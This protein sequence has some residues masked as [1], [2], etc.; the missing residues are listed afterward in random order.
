[1]DSPFWAFSLLN[2]LIVFGSLFYLLHI[3]L[4][5]KLLAFTL[6]LNTCIAASAIYC[7]PDHWV[8]LILSVLLSGIFFYYI[9]K[10]SIAFL[11]SI[12]IL[13]LAVLVEYASLLLIESLHLSI[14]LHALLVAL[15]FTSALYAY[16]KF[17]NKMT[18]LPLKIELL[19]ILMA[20][21]TFIVFYVTIFIPLNKGD[22]SLSLF[23]LS[24]LLCYS[25]FLFVTAKILLQ[26]VR[27]ESML[28][29]KEL[30]Q[31]SF[32][33]YTM[34][35]EQMNRE[36]QQ[37]QHDYSNILVAIRGYIEVENLEGL[38]HYFEK[39]ISTTQSPSIRS[40]QQLEHIK[41]LELKGLLS[42]KIVKAHNLSIHMN[43]EIPNTIEHFFIESIDLVRLVGIL[44]DNAT[45]ASIQH[46]APQIELAILIIS[47]NQQLIVIRN[48]TVQSYVNLTKLFEENYSTKR[49]N[50]G[51]GLYNVQQ[52]LKQY[53]NITLN[54]Y[55]E[56]EWFVQELLIERG[57]EYA[58]SNM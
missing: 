14:I 12:V 22:I 45:E 13:L 10:K 42:A 29:Q 54:T 53:P 32:Y 41:L 3:R 38:K 24:L 18:I 35:L 36:I 9:T 31:E 19:L 20:I 27:K 56:D 30:V 40:L 33:E 52:L 46:Q 28:Q 34:Q 1:M 21:I 43:V 2:Y 39:M 7:A 50:Q 44:F 8:A 23:N 4:T 17:T 51:L 49:N 26:V 11:H 48:T 15:L 37:V 5:I 55:V 58:N 6:L 47:E 57:E 16:K 25:I